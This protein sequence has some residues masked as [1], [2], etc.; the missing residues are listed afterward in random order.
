MKGAQVSELHSN[1][2]INLGAARAED[3][4][5]LGELIQEKVYLDSGIKLEWEIKKV[6]LRCRLEPSPGNL[7]NRH[8]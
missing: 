8:E 4:E 7:E 3:F 5:S 2:L 6:G 1:F